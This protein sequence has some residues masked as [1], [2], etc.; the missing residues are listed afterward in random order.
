VE[1]NPVLDIC[2]YI[3]FREN[4]NFTI[5]RPAKF[6]G[7]IQFCSFSELAAAYCEGKLHPMDLK[8][9]VA[10]Q[11]AAILEP[12]RRYFTVNKEAAD[13]LEAIRQAKITR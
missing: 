8:N 9:G 6:G 2:K 7:N 11:L 1:Y 13:C 4:E 10:E 3:V 5:E 12:A